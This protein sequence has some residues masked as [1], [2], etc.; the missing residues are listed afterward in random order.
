ML[1]PQEHR[2]GHLGA[3]ALEMPFG[4]APAQPEPHRIH[5]KRERRIRLQAAISQI[6][7]HQFAVRPNGRRTRQL[8][9]GP[10]HDARLDLHAWRPPA[11]VPRHGLQLRPQRHP[12]A[13]GRACA[14][15]GRASCHVD[16]PSSPDDFPAP[17]PPHQR[18]VGL[19][20]RDR[21][22]H[23]VDAERGLVQRKSTVSDPFITRERQTARRTG[24]AQRRPQPPRRSRRAQTEPGRQ[25]PK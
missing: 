19:D 11:K 3:A 7:H 23:P 18:R 8:R 24:R 4:L 1:R 14:R 21:R 25:H 20:P 5:R 22:A 13:T 2:P 6:L 15:L 17:P 10:P 16:R 12:A 9:P